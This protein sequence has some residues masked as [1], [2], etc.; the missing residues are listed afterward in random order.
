MTVT[1]SLELFTCGKKVTIPGFSNEN[2]ARMSGIFL[3]LAHD[4]IALF[5]IA[6]VRETNSHNA[7]IY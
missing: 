2:S 6:E 4:S 1:Y 7:D 5:E 3:Q